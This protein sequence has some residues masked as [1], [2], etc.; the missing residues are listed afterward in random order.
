MCSVRGCFEELK[1]RGLCNRHYLHARRHGGDPGAGEVEREQYRPI[2]G[3]RRIARQDVACAD[4]PELF[5]HERPGETR[6]Q[7]R[8][9]FVQAAQ[10]CRGCPTLELCRAAVP[11][12]RFTVSQID[13]AGV[14]GGYMITRRHAVDLLAG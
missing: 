8:A 13:G 12:V 7:R 3:L 2:R 14:W 6:G 9:R 10:L 4:T 1:A 5:D 11:D